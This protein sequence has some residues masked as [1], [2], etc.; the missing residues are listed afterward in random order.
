YLGLLTPFGGFVDGE[1]HPP[2][3]V[4][5]HLRHERAVFSRD[6]LV[7]ERNKLRE[8]HYPGIILD[9][10]VH[11]AELDIE[12]LVINRLDPSRH[13]RH[14]AL[15]IAGH[16]RACVVIAVDERVDGVATGGNSGFTDTALL[17]FDVVGFF[18]ALRAAFDGGI[19]GIVHIRH[20][21]G[22][23]LHTIAVL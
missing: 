7:V 8:A 13:A 22:Y 6:V 16:E 1:F 17:A 9:P 20:A 2:R 23:I 12:H 5:H 14:V 18:H 4:L 10:V 11:L 19:I 21:Q 3:A 15:V